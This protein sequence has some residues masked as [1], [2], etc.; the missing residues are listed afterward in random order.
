MDVETRDMAR[1]MLLSTTPFII[2]QIPN[3]FGF[4]SGLRAV[5]LMVALIVT[6]IFLF[7]YFIYQVLPNLMYS[8]YSIK[9]FCQIRCYKKAKNKI[10]G[11]TSLYMT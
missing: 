2:M 5:T 9:S 6:V 11:H 10:D 8:W 1:I 7:L 3:V 4:S